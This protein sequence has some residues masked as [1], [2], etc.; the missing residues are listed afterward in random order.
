[1][2]GRDVRARPG[3]YNLPDH[4]MAKSEWPGKGD[5]SRGDIQIEIAPGDRQ[6]PDYGVGVVLNLW[7]WHIV[8]FKP[9]RAKKCELAH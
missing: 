8:P 9:V 1:L 3:I 2:A 4:F 6:G 5:D 7:H